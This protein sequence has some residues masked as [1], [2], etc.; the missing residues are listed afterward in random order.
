M[1][2]IVKQK[3]LPLVIGRKQYQREGNVNVLKPEYRKD[4][5]ERALR[6]SKNKVDSYKADKK[7]GYYVNEKSYKQALKNYKYLKSIKWQNYKY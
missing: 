7:A 6:L 2:L 4:A 3:K 1:G 5:Y